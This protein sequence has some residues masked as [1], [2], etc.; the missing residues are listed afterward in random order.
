M[1]NRVLILC[2]GET[3]EVYFKAL[4][5]NLGSLENV[6]VK[7]SAAK[8]SEPEKVVSE[9]VG[10][11]D[12]YDFLWCVFDYDNSPHYDE[13]IKN[14]EQNRKVHCAF[15]N[16]A[17]EFWFLLHFEN[18]TGAMSVKLLEERLGKHLAQKYSK[19]TN[20]FKAIC[21][22]I[23]STNTQS[24][25]EERARMLHEKYIRDQSGSPPSQWQ[26]STT[27]YKLTKEL[28]QWSEAN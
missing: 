14:A 10:M 26:S 15:S 9:A 16:M 18:C 17:I 23:L 6:T 8:H 27:V 4:R 22:K 24:V 19:K 5:E 2:A 13:A 11:S 12:L 21:K 7:V 28:A 20:G 3:D 1:Q 25:A